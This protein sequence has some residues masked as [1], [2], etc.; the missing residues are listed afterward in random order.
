M[1]NRRGQTGLIVLIIVLLVLVGAALFFLIGG[2]FIISGDSVFNG[3]SNCRN[4]LVP[5]QE[6]EI[7]REGLQARVVDV[8]D[9]EVRNSSRGSYIYT[10]VDLRNV[11]NTAGYFTVIFRYETFEDGIRSR[12]VREFIRPGETES[13]EEEYRIDFDEDVRW[14]YTY[15]SDSIERVGTVTKYRTEMRCNNGNSNSGMMI[16]S[17]GSY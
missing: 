11:D 5:Y 7:V 8:E 16:T 3:G 4:V 2:R 1:E 17:G 9:D 13:F 10:R 14:T 12:E 6:Q 15:E